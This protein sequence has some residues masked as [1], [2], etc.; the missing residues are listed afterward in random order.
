MQPIP[1]AVTACLYF[2]SVTSPAANTPSTDVIVESGSVKIY[3]LL[4]IFN[5]SLK[6]DEEGL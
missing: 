4:F 5:L 6:I 1:A 2:S 3:P